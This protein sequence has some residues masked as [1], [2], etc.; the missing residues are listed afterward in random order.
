MFFED[1]ED[2]VKGM[3]YG[4]SAEED[5]EDSGM[6]AADREEISDTAGTASD[7]DNIQW[8]LTDDE[9][10]V[11]FNRYDI[12]AYVFGPT[13]VK[14]P[15]ETGLVKARRACILLL[16]VNVRSKRSYAYEECDCSDL[17]LR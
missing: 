5:L 6:T 2:T 4:F 16:E 12:A 9:L 1:Y 7:I 13:A 3:F 14:S 11:I 8:Y 17:G 15:F 10:V